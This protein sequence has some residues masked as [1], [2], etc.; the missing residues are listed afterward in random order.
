MIE[1]TKWRLETFFQKK[2]C[3]QEIHA[4]ERTVLHGLVE[5]FLRV[6]NQIVQ[7]GHVL[8][9]LRLRQGRELEFGVV[10]ANR[11]L[12]DPGL[13]EIALNESVDLDAGVDTATR[14]VS[15]Q[16]LAR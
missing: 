11:L 5:L 9:V 3:L 6:R 10:L 15:R 7:L 14:D 12:N 8:S 2:K 16:R 13:T 1:K 4:L